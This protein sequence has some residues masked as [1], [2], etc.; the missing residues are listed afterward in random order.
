MATFELEEFIKEPSIIVFDLCRKADLLEIAEHFGVVVSRSLTKKEIKTAVWERLITIKVFRPQS[1]VPSLGDEP[2]SPVG[3][4]ISKGKAKAPATLPRFEAFT[5]SSSGSLGDARLKVRLARLQ[6]EAQEKAQLFEAQEKA[7]LFDAQ[8]RTER[9]AHEL[10]LR[11]LE[12]EAE[13]VKLR[14]MELQSA[15][16]RATRIASPGAHTHPPPRD[17]DVRRHVAL[18]PFR[19]TEV[20]A[21]FTTFERLAAALQ[22]PKDIW[23]TLLQCKFTGKAQ[24][25]IASLSLEDGLDYDLVKIAVLRAYELV[26]EAYRQKFRN[27]RKVSSQT[28]VEVAREK[29]ALFDKWCSASKATA[30]DTLRELVLLEEFKKCVPERVVVYLNEQKIVSLTKAAVF[31]EEFT[32]THKTAFMSPRSEKLPDSLPADSSSVT[33]YQTRKISP[34]H[35]KEQRECYYC[36]KGGHV[37]ADCYALKRKHSSQSP[38]KPTAFI[39]SAPQTSQSVGRP[40]PAVK[41][42]YEPFIFNGLVSL[43]G[44]PNDQKSVRMLRDTGASQSFLLTDAFQLSEATSCG[45]NVLVQGIEMGVLTV[46]LHRVHVQTD[47]VS[48]WFKVAVRP[49]LPVP[50]IVFI[51]G[52]DVAGGKVRPVLEVLNQPEYPTMLERSNLD[53]IVFPAC[54]LTRAQTRKWGGAVDLSESVLGS[55]LASDGAEVSKGPLG[56]EVEVKNN[57]T[58]V[59]LEPIKLPI[60]RE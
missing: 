25:V 10:A 23:T 7:R 9:L 53:P 28:Y 18:P 21:Y 26:P 55:L 12:I 38:V 15:E 1:P 56:P 54:V 5:P 22:W 40:G 51:M 20:D 35:H 30:Y 49:T 11:K 16:V 42:G 44:Q 32:L 41:T 13:T 47:L 8:E 2:K 19:E 58:L 46:P 59:D 43:T 39:R 27:H 31:A 37:M 3:A 14:Q 24:D 36:H 34:T 45:S 57:E 29:S 48:G 52:N 33:Q 17:Y 6:L 60:T 4:G 50:G